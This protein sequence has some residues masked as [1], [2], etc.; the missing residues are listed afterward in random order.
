MCPLRIIL[1]FL[2]ATLAGFFLVRNI[3]SQSADAVS[4]SDIDSRTKEINS[5]NIAVD[6]LPFSTKVLCVLFFFLNFS[7]LRH[8]LFILLGV[9]NMWFT[10]LFP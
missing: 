5:S 8:F 9:L 1:I 7:F 3:K 10:F 6:S 4:D 2:S